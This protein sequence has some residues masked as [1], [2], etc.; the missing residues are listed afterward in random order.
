MAKLSRTEIVSPTPKG[1]SASQIRTPRLRKTLG[2][3]IPRRNTLVRTAAMTAADR[4]CAAIAVGI[5][6]AEDAGAGAVDAAAEHARKAAAIFL[7]QN[8]PLRRETNVHTIL[9]EDTIR[10]ARSR[11]VSN[12]AILV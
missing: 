5:A 2:S 4:T 10:E 7:L 12:R 11:A 3:S 9:A 6:A 1:R 8:T